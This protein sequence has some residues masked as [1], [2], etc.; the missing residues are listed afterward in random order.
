VSG[1]TLPV[2]I[3]G[4]AGIFKTRATL[5]DDNPLERAMRIVRYVPP[6]LPLDVPSNV[7]AIVDRALAKDPAHR[8]PTA[9]ALAQ[10]AREAIAEL[11]AAARRHSEMDSAS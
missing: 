7:G 1:R 2:R 8:W 10:A 9:A 6:P 3:A 4:P 5:R 11:D